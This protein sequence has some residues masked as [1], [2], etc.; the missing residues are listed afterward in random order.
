MWCK[1]PIRTGFLNNF[2]RVLCV[3]QVQIILETTKYIIKGSLLAFFLERAL[4]TFNRNILV[5]ITFMRQP[6]AICSPSSNSWSLGL[7]Q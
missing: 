2:F 1:V 4:E 6:G 3:T 7:T 5:R